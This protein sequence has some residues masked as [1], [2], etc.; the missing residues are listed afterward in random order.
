MLQTAIGGVLSRRESSTWGINCS[1]LEAQVRGSPPPSLGPA[2]LAVPPNP[3][4]PP[5]CARLPH[6]L[7]HPVYVPQNPGVRASS[8]LLPYSHN[9]L[10][11][12]H[13]EPND[14]W[15]SFSPL[16]PHTHGGGTIFHALWRE[17]NVV[18]FLAPFGKIPPSFQKNQYL[19]FPPFPLHRAPD[20]LTARPPTHP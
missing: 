10:P 2:I 6:S 4:K 14:S 16:P 9:A 17:T 1:R 15:W 12:C 3:F 7:Q 5:L 19:G 11:N 13:L 8:L 20:H 18:P